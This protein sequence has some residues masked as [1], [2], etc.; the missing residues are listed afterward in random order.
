MDESGEHFL[1]EGWNTPTAPGRYVDIS[2]ITPVQFGEGLE[3]RPVVGES[4]MVNFV[5][6]SPRA[7]APRHAH[8]EEQIM[9]ALDGEFF[10]ELDGDVRVVRKGDLVVIP[11]WVP[12]AAW[13]EDTSCTAVDIF[14]PPRRVLL[15]LAD[16]QGAL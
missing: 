7:S 5:A 9:I 15:D 2:S 12:H 10:F 4:T 3:F 13:T 6:F 1:T 11:P 14:N 16:A 8:E